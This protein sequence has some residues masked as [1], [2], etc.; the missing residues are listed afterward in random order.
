MTIKEHIS[1]KQEIV[2]DVP[3]KCLKI[4]D[5]MEANNWKEVPEAWG[6]R[7]E[8][9]TIGLKVISIY[10]HSKTMRPSLV[11]CLNWYRRFTKENVRIVAM[12][13]FIEKSDVIHVGGNATDVGIP[14][15]DR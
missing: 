4:V 2:I 14:G 5:V 7:G 9:I 8:T 11:V 1:G 15:P 12:K 6:A 3:F 10:F 13:T